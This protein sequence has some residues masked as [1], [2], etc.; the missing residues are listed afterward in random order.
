M[1]SIEVQVVFDWTCLS[2]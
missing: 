1:F 2:K